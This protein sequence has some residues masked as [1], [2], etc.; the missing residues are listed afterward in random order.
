MTTI[1]LSP[2]VP[3]WVVVRGERFS[4]GIDVDEIISAQ[5]SGSSSSFLSLRFRKN[6]FVDQPVGAVRQV[7]R[8][9]QK[10]KRTAR[11][12]AQAAQLPL[13]FY[14]EETGGN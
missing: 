13:P 5:R 1:K 9:A 14:A 2:H 8:E 4:F 10:I 3:G 12:E 11:I 7:L 6:L